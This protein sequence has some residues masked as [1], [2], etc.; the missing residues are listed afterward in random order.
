[1]QRDPDLENTDI[2]AAMANKPDTVEIH[3][4]DST[5]ALDNESQSDWSS[6][7]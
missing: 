4:S 7:K 6:S 3:L 1:M 2:G 5:Q